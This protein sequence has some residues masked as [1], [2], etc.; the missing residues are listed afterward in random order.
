ML[1][2]YLHTTRTAASGL[3]PGAV[4]PPATL[5]RGVTCDAI[6]DYEHAQGRQDEALSRNWQSLRRYQAAGRPAGQAQALNN[7]GWHLA[8][9]Q[10]YEQALTYC[11]QALVIFREIDDLNN[12]AHTCD[13]LGFIYRHRGR[14]EQAIEYYQHA[15]DL[16]RATG[17]AY[18][19]ATCLS[20]LGDLHATVGNGGAAHRTWQQALDILTR[21][22][23]ADAAGVRARLSAA[24]AEAAAATI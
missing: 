3:N 20:C 2:F 15:L 24:A 1:D 23:H 8:G 10:E 4:W 11:Q 14:W 19:E 7:I 9:Q 17:D 5:Q 18:G 16:L 21:L 12:Q 22:D 13:S 6:A